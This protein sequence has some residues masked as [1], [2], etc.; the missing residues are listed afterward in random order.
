[1]KK[2][3]F[4][5]LLS[6]TAFSQN[7]TNKETINKLLL[8]TWIADYGMMN[9]LK[10]EKMGQMK[11]LIYTFKA[12][13]TYIMNKGKIGQWKYNAQKKCINLFLNGVLKST[14]IKLQAKSFVMA[15]S[16]DKNAPKG[17]KDFQIFFK[18]KI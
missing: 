11:E 2:L 12:D 5:L 16:P 9:G 7:I 17:I 3:L 13:N 6:T 14:I 4:L 10:I 8:K 15:L 18:P 1:M